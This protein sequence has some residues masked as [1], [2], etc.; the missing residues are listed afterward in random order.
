MNVTAG[1]FERDV[2]ERSREL[3]VVVDFRAAWCGPCRMFG[4]VLESEV[5]KR[6]ERLE[7]AQIDIEAEQLL[8]LRYGIRSIPTVAVFR[9]GEI[10][11]GFIG[12]YPAAAVGRFLD[13]QV[14][15]GASRQT[16]AEVAVE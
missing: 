11:T 6:A 3:P 12:A 4:P 9:D 13:E 14:L 1:A 16:P 8:A 10:L 2:L 7:L 15:G 5:A